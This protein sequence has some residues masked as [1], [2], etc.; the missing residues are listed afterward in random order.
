MEKVVM[1]PDDADR[2]MSIA[3]TAARLKTSPPVVSRLIKSGLLRACYFGKCTR[4]KKTTF[5]AFLAQCDGKNIIRL[6]EDREKEDKEVTTCSRKTH[7][8]T[9]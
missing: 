2:L 3:E 6:L 5:N 1:F 4:I 7:L 9:F 8:C